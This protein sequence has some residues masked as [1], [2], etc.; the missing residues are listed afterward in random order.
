MNNFVANRSGLITDIQRFSL[1]DGPGIRTI[2]FVKGCPLSCKWC[3]NPETKLFK[4]QISFTADKCI[5]CLNC[6]EVCH[7]HAHHIEDDI[8]QFN[9]SLCDLSG[10]CVIVCPSNALKI[11]G[12]DKSINEIMEIVLRDKDYYT[13]SGGGLT[14]SGGEPMNQFN[15]TRDLLYSAK[16]NGLH[17]VMETCGYAKQKHFHEIKP[18]VDLFLFDYKETNEKK[19]REHTGVEKKIIIENLRFLHNGGCDIILRCPIIFGVNDNEE[20]FNG[21]AKLS[22]ELPNLK[23]IELLA[24]HDIGRDKAA[25]IGLENEYYHISNTSEEMKMIWLDKLKSLNCLNVI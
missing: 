15:F 7:T 23:G 10:S 5:N 3:H 24:Y 1:H 13:N 18:L 2:V 9:F 20:H 19:H 6:V 21:I 16:L 11:I 8:H 14:I 12:S 25:Q 4:P 22:K 17:T